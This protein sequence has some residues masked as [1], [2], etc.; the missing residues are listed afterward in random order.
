MGQNLLEKLK[1][2]ESW[3]LF[4]DRDGVINQE[5]FEKY[6]SNPAEF[7]FLERAPEALMILASIF[8]RIVV[9]TNQQGVGKGLMSELDL[10]AVNSCM[11]EEVGKT[12]GRID[13]VYCATELR[14][15][16]D[17]LRK[18]GRGMADLAKTE[19]PMIDF[20]K[21]I[22][23]GNSESDIDFGKNLGMKTVFI[24]ELDSTEALFTYP[25]LFKFA[26][27]LQC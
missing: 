8:K 5:T 7:F 15:T 6:I 25:S 16:I 17:G 10:K 27:G 3:T 21:S 1:V 12:G 20:E 9:V 26:E 4:L 19:Y 22:M 14:G 18:P 11:L 13:S 23:V 24:G 2:D